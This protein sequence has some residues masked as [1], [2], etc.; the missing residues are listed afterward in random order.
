MLVMLVPINDP[1]V[2]LVA[3]VAV[4]LVPILIVCVLPAPA[5]VPILMVLVAVDWPTVIIPV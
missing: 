4:L 1:I 3:L 5:T 2:T